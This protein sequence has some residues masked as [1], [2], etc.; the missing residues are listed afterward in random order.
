MDKNKAIQNLKE[1]FTS[2]NLIPVRIARITLE[3]YEA[4]LPTLSSSGSAVV[5]Q[6]EGGGELMY[7]EGIARD[8]WTKSD[9]DAKERILELLN[10]NSTKQKIT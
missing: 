4:I 6:A 1:K 3:E 2:S 8:D 10:E 7:A 5:S 9:N